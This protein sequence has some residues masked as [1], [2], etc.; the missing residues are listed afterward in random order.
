MSLSAGDR[1]GPY[2]VVGAIGAGGMGEVYR[3]RDG[4]LHRDVA[5]KVLPA[6]FSTDEARLRRFEKEA[7]A[8]SALNHPGI[9]TIYDFGDHDGSPYLVAEL[10]DGETLRER[11]GGDRLPLRKAIDY[12]TQVARGL[13][14]A[15]EKGIVH[16][17]LKPE[18]LFVT[19][20]GRVKILDFGLA[21][22][23]RPEPD[24][25]PRATGATE[26]APSQPGL[27]LG[28]AGYL[29]PE[30]V[31]G[32]PAD[33]RSDLFSLG[34]ILYEMLTGE[35]AF[36]GETPVETLNAILKE[37][38]LESSRTIRELPEPLD[39]IVRHCLEK[40][41]DERFQS[42]HDVA[43][44]LEAV[45]ASGA[46]AT[47][48]SAPAVR[49]RARRAVPAAVAVAAFLALAIAGAFFAG[50]SAQLATEPI[51][52]RRVTF[53]H[54]NVLNARFTPDGE[55]VVY[56]AAWD[57][58]PTEVFV[59]RRDGT[60]SSALGVEKADV[61]SVSPKG[62]LAVLR[63]TD[64]LRGAYGVGTLAVL[65]LEGGTP[66]DLV[67][68]VKEADFGPDGVLAVLRATGGPRGRQRIEY[69]PGRVL[70]ESGNELSL[71]D[72]SP[73]GDVVAFVE[74][75]DRPQIRL[76]DRNGA[77]RAVPGEW[78]G[79]T[80]LRFAPG[81]KHL[82]VM[83]RRTDRPSAIVEY[84]FDGRERVVQ[85]F[86][87]DYQLHDVA[88]DGRLLIEE[89]HHDRV[90]G[91]SSPGTPDR[92]LS[93]LDLSSVAD[94]ARD[95]RSVLFN[96]RG[97]GGGPRGSI[98]LRRLSEVEPVRLGE[99]AGTAISDDGAWVLARRPGAPPS[100][101][102]IPV[103]AG[104]ERVLNTSGLEAINVSQ[105][106]PGT[107]DAIVQ[108]RKKEEAWRLYEVREG[109][110]PPRPVSPAI[111]HWMFAVAPD[112][113]AVVTGDPDNRLTLYPLDGGAP[114]LLPG[115]PPPLYALQWSADGKSILVCGADL[116]FRLFRYELATG[117]SE[118]LR[119]LVPSDPVS[120][121]QI[122]GATA[123]RDFRTI[124]YSWERVV[125]SDLYV[126]EPAR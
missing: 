110:N 111:G 56:G 86:T 108:G 100:L 45:A 60:R 16:R 93:W 121:L 5:I 90:L 62:D 102:R 7:R 47:G 59:T 28:T 4:R 30:Q 58:R 67:T 27:A 91:L 88:A 77:V 120:A 70:F 39:R 73:T 118:L 122:Y 44:D 29:S 33:P 119:D 103:G 12:G 55:S 116:P 104:E 85:S 3:A 80:G 41:R 57:G 87:D 61:L 97:E 26:T 114:R 15:H 96:E 66:R 37:D 84:G 53:R 35:R 123:T 64:F 8:A 99:G 6:A 48:L 101:V 54:G 75:S 113:R 68:D 107:L 78:I 72:V 18:N 79:V 46:G 13:A 23:T 82:V 42:A 105:F 124:A 106:L 25:A 1:L 94:V 36:R 43:F 32:V 74:R 71:V 83:G 9:L 95:G 98:Y 109:A 112:G 69:P 17:D 22:L 76:A 117:R 20:D 89:S 24:G 38:P 126:G 52:L 115:L 125:V 51:D 49:R 31:R 65:P 19:N 34:A 40:S 63:K 11:L 92:H 14:A 2:E 81:G 21:K 50:R 10:L